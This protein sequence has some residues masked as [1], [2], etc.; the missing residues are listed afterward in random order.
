M[1]TFYVYIHRRATNGCIFYV[2]KGRGKR[3]HSDRN[4]NPYWHHIVAKH[5]HTIHFVDQELDEAT[6]F[7][8]ETFMI[9][10]CG[11]DTLCNMTNGGEGSSGCY[12]TDETREKIGAAS[13]A[14]SPESRAK[15]SLAI[16]GNDYAL[17][18][19]LSDETREKMSEVSRL[20]RWSSEVKAKMSES[21]K[22]RWALPESQPR[23]E[24]VGAVHR[25]KPMAQE[26]RVKISTAV[27]AYYA[28]LK[29]GL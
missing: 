10:F 9:E 22:A 23:R 4:R 7:E 1:N 15:Q 5:G 2:G 20:R 19:V 29:G 18:N 14:Q 13:K 3:A 8:L 21:A 17:G 27:N 25:G 16:R 6:A 24:M 28:K 11:R 26:Q 12:P